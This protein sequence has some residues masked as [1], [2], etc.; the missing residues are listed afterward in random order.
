MNMIVI[1]NVTVVKPENCFECCACPLADCG[2][3]D[4][5]FYKYK[6]NSLR[7]RLARY[8]LNKILQANAYLRETIV[9]MQCPKTD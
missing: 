5:N 7:R 8:G 1:P 4:S 3:G 2:S 6:C 9:G